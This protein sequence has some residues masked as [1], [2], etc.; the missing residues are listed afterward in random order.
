MKRLYLVFAA[1]IFGLYSLIGQDVQ[2]RGTITDAEEGSPVPGAYVRVKGT[3]T[4]TASDASGNYQLTVPRDATLVFTSIGYLEQEVLVNNQS[5]IDVSLSPDVVQV[6]EVVV[7]ALGIPRE[8]K[9]LGYATQEVSGEEVSTVKTDNFI[10]TLSGKLAGV[11]IKVNNNIGG[12]TNVVIRGSKSLFQSNQALFV[13]DGVP[14]DNSN[15]N[16]QGQING[17]SGYDYGNAAS[18]INP[19]D[20]E[21][22]SVL[23]GAAA[24]AL[25]GSRAANGVIMITTKKGSLSSGK[26]GVSLSS[27]VTIG[28]IDKSTFPEYQQSYGAGYLNY[29]YSDSDRPALEKYADIDGDGVTDFTVP[30]YDDASFGEAFDPNLLV[31]QYH[32]FVPE[33]EHYLQPTPW[34][35]GKNGPIKFFETAVTY[36]NSID[37]SGGTE[38]STY[39]MA[40]T[41]MDQKGIMPNS[42]LKRNILTLSGSHSFLPNLTVSGS[43]NF[44]VTD[45]KGRNTTGYSDNIL[46]SFRQWW[47][48]NVD[49]LEQKELFERTGRNVTWNR[50]AYDDPTPAYWDNPYWVAFKNFETDTRRRL[51]GYAQV[52]YRATDWLTFTGRASID[53]YNELQEERKAVGSVA[54]ELGVGRPDVTSGYSRLTRTLLETNI[55][56]HANIKKDLTED[57]NLTALIGSNF[58]RSELDQVFASTNNGLSVPDVYALSVSVDPMLPPEET[59]RKV[60]INGYFGSVSLGYRNFV[61]LEGT[62]RRDISSTLP[63]QHW[64]Y[65]YPSISGSLIF[66]ELLDQPWLSFGKL[67]LNYAEVGN[68]APWGSVEDSYTPIAPFTGN[69]LVSVSGTK[70][71]PDLRPERTKSVEGGLEMNFFQNRLGFDLALYRTKTVDLI[72]PIQVSFATG[73]TFKF[74]NAGEMENKGVE[75][76]LNILP[77]KLSNFEWRINL[78]WALNRNQVLSLPEGLQNL[79][80]ND[81]LQAVSINARINEPYG[82]IQGTDYVYH[83]NGQR[84]V[85]PDGYYALTPTSDI[86]IGNINPDWTGGVLNTFTIK[87]LRLGFLIDIQQGGDIF[88]LDQWYGQA[89]GLYPESVYINDLGNP[90]RNSVYNVPLDPS[91]GLSPEAGGLILPGVQADGSPN[92]VRVEG[93]DYRVWGYFSRPNSEFIYD[94]SF[95]K[96]RE[97]TLGYDLPSKLLARTFINRVSIMFVGSNLWIIKKNLPYADP[98]AGQSS[99]NTQG[100]QTGVM[101]ATRSF[102]VTL[103]VEF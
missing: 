51:L 8:K 12:S 49:V 3:N 77:V 85:D 16:N 79:P 18:D 57:L 97:V 96:L 58:R 2:V 71:N 88:S 50:N 6:S 63:K 26:V 37:L 20:I 40:Y 41:N 100:F 64:A 36:T 92:T 98:E 89:T 32:A 83:E 80:I 34:V 30:Y 93:G 33:S 54:G 75:V 103:N 25:Y 1:F 28:V 74:L 68:G 94:A 84:I 10:N 102:G 78:N 48:I 56:L 46:T 43:A 22:I 67:R 14:V 81:G 31:Y 95:V 45:G 44:T 99:G 82:A 72:T 21:S 5:V 7:T 9:S 101:P 23:K 90:V 4:G 15:T 73:Y 69:P 24:T 17:R 29:L 59:F 87:G 86:V 38:K 70:N 27:N 19:N 60:G 76:E 11:N 62:F 39:R 42:S 35:A 53:T 13:I 91:S 65:N 47:Q 55:D 66:S 61:Y 52:E